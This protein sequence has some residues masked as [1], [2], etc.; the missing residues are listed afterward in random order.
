VKH[1]FIPRT[2]WTFPYERVSAPTV[3]N[4]TQH[5][6]HPLLASWSRW[7]I[8]TLR[9]T[10]KSVTMSE[11][12]AKGDDEVTLKLSDRPK[13]TSTEDNLEN[14]TKVHSVRPRCGS[15]SWV[16]CFG[17]DDSTICEQSFNCTYWLLRQYSHSYS[18]VSVHRSGN[19]TAVCTI[20]PHVKWS[21]R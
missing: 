13:R 17:I 1:G 5:V 7:H 10:S 2:K 4:Q 6:A 19:V 14:G 11:Q 3:I 21:R 20:I 8:Y 15:Y 9:P 12:G 16:V 18:I